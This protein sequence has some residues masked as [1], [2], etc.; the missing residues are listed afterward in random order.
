PGG[1]RASGDDDALGLQP[2]LVAVAERHADPA[3]AENR[4]AAVNGIDL[5]LLEQVSD[6]VDVAF[7]ALILERQHPRE[8]ELRSGRNTH[9]RKA[10][11][12]LLVGVRRVQHGLGGDAA[13]VKTRSAVRCA[14][15]DDGH[16]EPELGRPDGTYVPARSG[17]D[18]DEVVWVS[19][20][21][22]SLDI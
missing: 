18:H 21:R 10:V 3:W 6:A 17:A 4:R 8:I 13:H 15:L 16:L 12:R 14:L 7:D 9:G 1:V 11:T 20:L 5:V 2:L 22:G 19:H